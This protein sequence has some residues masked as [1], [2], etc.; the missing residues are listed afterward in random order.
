[1]KITIEAISPTDYHKCIVSPS[2]A[3]NPPAFQYFKGVNKNFISD[4]ITD[5]RKE[6]ISNFI[7]TMLS[8]KNYPNPPICSVTKAKQIVKCVPELLNNLKYC[9]RTTKII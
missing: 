6:Q 9:K 8:S 5:N 3:V 4:T 7:I 2:V 1:M